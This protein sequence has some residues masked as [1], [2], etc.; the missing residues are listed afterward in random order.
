MLYDNRLVVELLQILSTS[1]G[2]SQ[3]QILAI[4]GDRLCTLANY[5]NQA[6]AFL[7]Y[8][9]NLAMRRERRNLIVRWRGHAPS[10]SINY[11]DDLFKVV[12]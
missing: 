1:D 2:L 6:F 11:P 5:L 4:K 10:C 7:Q 12:R 8:T 9:F 3:N